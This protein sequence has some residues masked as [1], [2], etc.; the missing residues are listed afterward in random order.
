MVLKRMTHT[1]PLGWAL[2]LDELE[3]AVA[4]AKPWGPEATLPLTMPPNAFKSSTKDFAC[5][6]S[7]IALQGGHLQPLHH[8][9]H[10]QHE[11]LG[12]EVPYYGSGG[13]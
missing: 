1:W 2:G 10:L 9:L 5:C 3:G 13:R 11:A 8:G 6:P 7:K 4:T 12:V